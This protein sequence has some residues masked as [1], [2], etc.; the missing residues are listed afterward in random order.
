MSPHLAVGLL[1]FLFF[2]VFLM[3]AIV[4]QKCFSVDVK[5]VRN[6]NLIKKFIFT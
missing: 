4:K 2:F 3:L 1:L 5:D 6:K